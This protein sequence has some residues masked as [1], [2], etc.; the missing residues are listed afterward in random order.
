MNFLTIEI[1]I[2]S[3]EEFARIPGAKLHVKTGEETHEIKYLRSKLLE[4]YE[5]YG[6]GRSVTGRA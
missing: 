4:A 2:V 1:Q 3:K 6:W 5:K